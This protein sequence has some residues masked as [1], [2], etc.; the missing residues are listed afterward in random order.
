MMRAAA[1]VAP[2]VLQEAVHLLTL[3]RRSTWRV[4]FH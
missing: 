3:L 1:L 4:L 2:K